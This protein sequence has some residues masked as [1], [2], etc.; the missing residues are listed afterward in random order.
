ML[1]WKKLVLVVAL[2]I[3]EVTL[4][5][6][7]QP[8]PVG[9][10][11]PSLV[12]CEE[13]GYTYEFRTLREPAVEVVTLV[14]ST[15][16]A[17]GSEVAPPREL[18]GGISYSV[19]IFPDGTECE[20]WSF[21]RGECLPG[22]LEHAEEGLPVIN[23]VQ[24]AGLAQTVALE[25]LKLN[26]Q[27]SDEPYSHLMTISDEGMLDQ[28][29]AALDVPIWTFW[30][31]DCTTP[32]KLHFHLADGSVQE[33]EYHARWDRTTEWDFVERCH[34][35]QDSIL[36]GDQEFLVAGDG[37]VPP[38]TF[39]AL[40]KQQIASTWAESVNVAEALELARTVEI[41][42]LEISVEDVSRLTTDD[43]QVIEQIVVALDREY[44]FVTRAGFHP[45]F[46]MQFRLDDGTVQILHFGGQGD[47]PTVLRGDPGIWE[48]R[49]I[50]PSADFDALIETL[51]ASAR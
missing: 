6:C 15:E 17:D 8:G 19:C 33:F 50:R 14:P 37:G 20:A 32:Y 22:Q 9:M 12:Y 35:N 16:A 4:T 13:Q 24:E 7:Q 38:G 26:S 40:I 27:P 45:P 5:A 10:P 44:E 3:M 42:I 36:R 51:L 47:N 11:N 48:G 34:P 21:F 25:I 39:D 18:D 49:D 23:V 31:E 30:Q 29:I 41:E 43:P 46:E 28:I 2:V 1:D